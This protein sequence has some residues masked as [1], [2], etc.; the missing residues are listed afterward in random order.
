M[1]VLVTGHLGYVGPGVI[2]SLKE[3]G[4]RVTGLDIGYFRECVDATR[5]PVQADRELTMDIRDVSAGVLEG[6]DA[7]VHLAGLS[8]DP[9]GQLH[10]ELT[11]AI[12][13]AGT[14]R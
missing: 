6:I 8:N 1:H 13:H 2:G 4:H 7:I 9:L 11:S 10:P 5:L 12:N 14:A 3:A